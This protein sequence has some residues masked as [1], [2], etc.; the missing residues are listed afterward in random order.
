MGVFLG[1]T[2]SLS[3]CRGTETLKMK[4]GK[5]FF[6]GKNKSEHFCTTKWGGRGVLMFKYL[7]EVRW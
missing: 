5:I 7:R 4:S 2:I 6:G 1:L 3:C